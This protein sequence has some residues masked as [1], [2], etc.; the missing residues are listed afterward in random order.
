MKIVKISA[1]WCPSCLV[2][3]P[4]FEQI[5]KMYPNIESVTFDIDLDEEAKNYNAGNILPVFILLNNQ[6][7]EIGRLKGEQ[8]IDTLSKIIEEHL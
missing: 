4:R 1:V 7:V 5:E 2:M 3:R 6:D 8:K